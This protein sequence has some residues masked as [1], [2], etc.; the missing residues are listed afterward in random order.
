MEVRAAPETEAATAPE[1]VEV[2]EEASLDEAHQQVSRSLGA[3]MG[4]PPP[5]GTSGHRAGGPAF[6]LPVSTLRNMQ[7][8]A[9]N[10]ATIAVHRQFEARWGDRRGIQRDP[11][12]GEA[13]PV[14]DVSVTGLNLSADTVTLPLAV[15]LSA[16]VVPADATGVTFSVANGTADASNVSI[17]ASTGV[18]TIAAGQEGG[19][20]AVSADGSDGSGVTVDL[21]IIE[22]PGAISATTAAGAA[23]YGGQFT[24]T[25]TAPSGRAAGLEGV[26]INEEFD[27][28]SATPPWGGTFQLTANAAGSHGWDLDATGKMGG[29]DNVTIGA[30]TVNIG[31]VI[32]CTSNPNA[33]GEMP[34]GFTMNQ[35]LFSKVL[36]GGAMES[37]PFATVAHR[38]E[39]TADHRFRVSAGLDE[40]IEDYSG[41]DAVTNAAA[42]SSTVMASPPRPESGE[43]AQRKVTISADPIP[44]TAALTYSITGP[45]LGCTVDADGEVSIGSTAGTITVRVTAA[46]GN[47][48]EVEITITAYA[49]PE[50]SSESAETSAPPAPR[51][52]PPPEPVPPAGVPTG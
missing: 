6:G 13:A 42:S 14:A 1:L 11:G 8:L 18:I 23:N 52:E 39:L 5:S 46:P 38:R 51:P 26:N 3:L 15:A 12:D 50:S 29:P 20:V 27:S 31:K 10:Q 48:D 7:R 37:T 41:P 2:P 17:D 30:G 34:Q 43:W 4:V 44:D 36:P 49:E 32:D 19:T 16:E 45:N 40:I 9:G 22:R 35:K 25:F 47:Y 21:D 33:A 28:T 24:H